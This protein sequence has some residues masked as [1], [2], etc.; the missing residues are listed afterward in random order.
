M[1]EDL[2]LLFKKEKKKRLF[3]ILI[4]VISVLVF[5]I[6]APLGV[7]L[8]VGGICLYINSTKK[9]KDTIASKIA[10]SVLNAHIDDLEY[11]PNTSFDHHTIREVYMDFPSYDTIESNDV[12][13][14]KYKGH[15]IKM[16]DLSLYD[17]NYVSDGHG[18]SRREKMLVFKGPY[19]VVSYDRTISS[20]VTVAHHT[21]LSS[22]N[23]KTESEEFNKAYNVTSES[24]HDAFY[25]LTPHM[26]ER[27]KRVNELAGDDIYINFNSDRYIY[28]AVN[29]NKNNFEI[30]LSHSSVK[31]IEQDFDREF[32]YLMSFI[33]ELLDGFDN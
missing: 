14:G 27:I 8:F 6:M 1:N 19:I 15:D 5:I 22:G 16:C 23:V 33:D 11:D 10:Y 2:D 25:I 24:E 9:T 20:P 12:I 13:K 26:M 29:N 30:S 28:L 17:I 32:T 21:F 31:E 3:Y 4:I 7:A 18:G